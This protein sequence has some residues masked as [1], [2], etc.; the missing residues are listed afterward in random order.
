MTKSE[1]LQYLASQSDAITGLAQRIWDNPEVAETESFAEAEYEKAF[2]AA[3]FA[4]QKI[5]LDDPKHSLNHAFVAEYGAGAPV[6]AILGEYDA[7]P[8]LSQKAQA[9]REPVQ[10]GAPG[11][12]CGHNLL[13]AAGFGAALALKEYLAQ[14]GQSGTI[15]YYGCP[16]EETLAGKVKML[17][18]GCF[19]GCDVAL[20]WHPMTANAPL[21]EGFLANNGL[22]FRFHGISSHAAAS[23]EAGR[24]ALDAVELMN[25]GA[26][27]LREHI[28]DNARVHY[29]ITNAG[30]APNIVPAFA[31]SWYYV[32]APHRKDVAEITGRLLDIA[33]GAALMTGTTM[34]YEVISGCYEYLTNSVMFDLTHQN[35]LE[36]PLPAYTDEEMQLAKDLQ[37]SLDPSVVEKEAAKMMADTGSAMHT[38]VIKKEDCGK[39]SMAGS[40][41][42]G[43]VSWNM[44]MNV[45]LTAAWP[46]GTAAHTWQA[47]ASSG[48]ALG[49]RGMLYAAGVFAAM[50]Y[51]LLND[52]AL[53][54]SAKA[55][56][57][58]R[59]ATQKYQNPL[60]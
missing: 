51:D 26:N 34:D 25:V 23:P 10:E 1:L 39:I 60:L 52:P 21:P 18:T 45:L 41:D 13:G 49:M 20:S 30:G 59:T 9:A 54:Q 24:S 16:E 43:D 29:T 58:K 44:P 50:A 5:E 19:D 56:F 11:H 33:R 37:A 38:G 35:M 40:S 46:I 42:S 36:V 8:Q 28:P 55:E 15:R 2:K 17:L 27:Y 47:C 3:G 4:F 7:L 14:S 53:V 48:S 31:E 32:R 6:I 12:G 57:E 22:K